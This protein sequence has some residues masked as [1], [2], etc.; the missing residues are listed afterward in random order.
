MAE[1]RFDPGL[2]TPYLVAVVSVAAAFVV[3]LLVDNI[4]EQEFSPFVFFSAP[5]MATAWYG[6][7]RPAL[8][9]L[10]LATLLADLFFLP[11]LYSPAVESFAN[12]V[13][14]FGFLLEGSLI[15]LLAGMLHRAREEAVVHRRA[16]EEAYRQSQQHVE[17][18][19]QTKNALVD[20]KTRFRR[21]VD[22]NII[23]VFV[24]DENGEV[25]SANDAFLGMLGYTRE[26]TDSTPLNLRTLATPGLALIDD[27]AREELTEKGKC[28]PHEKALRSRSGDQIPV[29]FGAVR[30]G[31]TDETAICFI[32]D[33]AEFKKTEAELRKA[34]GAAEEA[35]R[36]KSEF[37]ANIS[38]EL[39]TPMNVI[40]GMTDLVLQE[41][42]ADEVHDSLAIARESADA[43]L[44]LL[45]DLLDFSKMESGKFDL[46]PEPFSLPETLDATLKTLALPASEKGLELNCVVHPDVPCRLVG[47]AS[48]LR[49]VVSNL[50]DNA[51]KF[52][53][54][55]EVSVEVAVEQRTDHNAVLRFCVAD[56]GIGISPE[57]QQRIFAPFTQADSSSTRAYHGSGLGLSIAVELVE[58]MG[59]AAWLESEVGGGS[60]FYF[61]A[62]FKLDGETKIPT[63]ATAQSV[64]LPDA[65]FSASVLVVEDTPANW[66]LL[67]R[68]LRKRGHDVVI[69]RNGREALERCG[70]QRFDAV[71]MDVQMPTMDGFQATA[72]IRAIPSD[73]ERHGTPPDVPVIAMTAHAMKSD[74]ARCLAAGMDAYVSKP[75]DAKRLLRTIEKM[76]QA[77]RSQADKDNRDTP[78]ESA[79]PE[80]NVELFAG[81]GST[82]SPTGQAEADVTEIIDLDAALERLGG[83]RDLL[84]HMV[85]LFFEDFPELLDRIDTMAEQ[86]EPAEV[87]R[88]AHSLKGL[89]ANFDG[90][91]AVA[92]ALAVEDAA[93][94]KDMNQVRRRVPQL[95]AEV[96][97]LEEA[98][99][100]HALGMED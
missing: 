84:R 46:A 58:R 56:T 91:P 16:V 68:I 93:S 73:E 22:A 97:R 64:I 75:V 43:L 41:D 89:C 86:N 3:K 54:R 48:R 62:K 96:R 8:F 36:A 79:Y 77:S 13:R 39:R 95:K 94:A 21:L 53:E 50:V 100:P 26:E 35:N 51:V 34:V 37:L 90:R 52:T 38:H 71:L 23:G 61:N 10:A 45:N 19:T 65:P 55:G 78:D 85:R 40:I 81:K 63:E 66:H 98:L 4:A 20:S 29:L 17:E 27:R 18:L 92:A 7:A 24:V 1:R 15:C 31:D 60:K 57:D 70:Q 49:Q 2:L 42:L 47:D 59:G 87:Q 88:A 44:H 32:A 28:Q 6:G 80:T 99:K 5:I 14:L 72:A 11:P 25:T 33:L 12:H 74:E 69:A 30:V 82:P 67:E 76:V 9:S 83:D